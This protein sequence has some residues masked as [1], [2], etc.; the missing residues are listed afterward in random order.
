[1]LEPEADAGDE[2]GGM[3]VLAGKP[4]QPRR[5]AGFAQIRDA[6]IGCELAAELIAQARAELYV[7]QPRTDVVLRN[8]L[9]GEIDLGARLRYEFCLLYTSPSPRDKRQSRMPSSA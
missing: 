7:D 1:M 3:D 8:I 6:D 4:R 2:A 5:V 9:R